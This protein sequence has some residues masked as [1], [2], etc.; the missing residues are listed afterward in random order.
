MDKSSFNY[1]LGC[2]DSF[3]HD[4]ADGDLDDES[5][6][7][8]SHTKPSDG[9]IDI[10]RESIQAANITEDD[11]LGFQS[12]DTYCYSNDDNNS[13][14]D[15]TFNVNA[16]NFSQDQT[17]FDTSQYLNLGTD[18][19]CDIEQ[20]SIEQ[21]SKSPPVTGSCQNVKLASKSDSSNIS[22][23]DNSN[24]H[25]IKT[26]EVNSLKCASTSARPLVV[27]SQTVGSNRQPVYQVS[28]RANKRI[29]L[30][31]ASEPKVVNLQALNIVPVVSGQSSKNEQKVDSGMNSL[32]VLLPNNSV[33]VTQSKTMWSS[34]ILSKS[35][36]S[37]KIN[38]RYSLQV[39][40]EDISLPQLNSSN[41]SQQLTS[42]SKEQYY[43]AS[44]QQGSL[45]T[46]SR[47]TGQVMI[48]PIKSIVQ[49]SQSKTKSSPFVGMRI[50]SVNIPISAS[51]NCL[52][53]QTSVVNGSLSS[54]KNCDK[55]KQ[56]V[57]NKNSN[58]KIVKYVFGNQKFGFQQKNQSKKVQLQKIITQ[59]PSFR[60]PCATE[61]SD[62]SKT[63]R[64]EWKGNSYVNATPTGAAIIDKQS[65][66]APTRATH[67]TFRIDSG[68]TANEIH[69]VEKAIRERSGSLKSFNPQQKQF[70]SAFW[71]HIHSMEQTIQDYYIRNP[72]LFSQKV[73][74]HFLK[75]KK[76]FL[77]VVKATTALVLNT[78]SSNSF[79]SKIDKSAN[80]P[81]I[82]L[83]RSNYRSMSPALC[84]PQT[85]DLNR[86]A[87]KR[88]N[89]NNIFIKRDPEVIPLKRP[90]MIEQRLQEHQQLATSPDTTT[91]F[92]NV[93]DCI[94]RLLPFHVYNVP[95]VPK[96]DFDES[97]KLFDQISGNTFNKM[98]RMY[99]KY[100]ELFFKDAARQTSSPDS[101]MLDRIFLQD[102][103]QR[104]IKEKNS[105]LDN[106]IHLI[107][108]LREDNPREAHLANFLKTEAYRK[109]EA[110]KSPSAQSSV[111]ETPS[112]ENEV[113]LQQAVNSIL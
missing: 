96:L 88:S 102:E 62:L 111:S 57:R 103:R 109:A 20:K 95:E 63:V 73:N 90:S 43:I 13:T 51:S 60:T 50:A 40:S 79:S 14:C 84:K 69:Q 21:S 3:F 55:Q 28:N 58:D 61:L 107:K 10:L 11:S 86:T 93:H 12:F 66:P 6:F 77:L 87:I 15:L 5:E 38:Q 54:S 67:H 85:T 64:K 17:L 65:R 83:T 4:F 34:P 78:S 72:H 7:G 24:Q 32:T 92:R 112:I 44:L 89:T 18:P 16:N 70:H 99:A 49:N 47:S 33:D 26:S 74:K 113:L 1:P 2:S 100:H 41:S 94:Q 19:K 106:P 59:E 23:Y 81:T 46:H 42:N 9:G 29:V 35:T 27:N 80:H 39:D 101:V 25:L 76:A 105:I 31:K 36:E 56:F 82:S 30:V 68:L 52:T 91:P 45:Q 71:A 22:V 97:E 110:L 48:R 37:S 104:F 108:Y 75:T 53:G 98:F 8:V